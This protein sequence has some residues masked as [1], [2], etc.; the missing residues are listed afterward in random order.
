LNKSIER[1][2]RLE[3]VWVFALMTVWVVINSVLALGGL[4]RF[5]PF[6]YILPNLFLSMWPGCEFGVTDRSLGSLRPT[7]GR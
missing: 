5:D 3:E 7:C 6:P 1:F 2:V 4:H